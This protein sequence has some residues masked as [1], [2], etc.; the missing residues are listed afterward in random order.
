MADDVALPFVLRRVATELP[1]FGY[2]YS[3]E[4]ELCDGIAL[5][6]GD[7]HLPFEREVTASP[8]DRFDFV[9]GNG[10]VLEVKMDGSGA[11]A[12]MQCAR[13]CEHDMVS[14][15]VLLAATQW[16]RNIRPF[17]AH[18]KQVICVPL[19]RQAF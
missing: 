3:N 5:V 1:R 7:L 15:V 6:L 12:L 9:M 11:D 14:A 18:G 17:K 10:I 16:A 19:T 4:K 13:Y 8:R 2:R